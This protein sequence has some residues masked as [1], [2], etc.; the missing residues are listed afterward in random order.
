MILSLT[1]RRHCIA[2]YS[3]CRRSEGKAT[4][5]NCVAWRKSSRG[6][7]G[8]AERRFVRRAD[9]ARHRSVPDFLFNFSTQ[10]LLVVTDELDS[11]IAGDERLLDV[12]VHCC[13]YVAG[14][15]FANTWSPGLAASYMISLRPHH[16]SWICALLLHRSITFKCTT[17]RYAN[18]QLTLGI[19]FHNLNEC[20]TDASGAEMP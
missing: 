7:K 9:L 11:W 6:L 17:S 13:S 16:F 12:L 2:I 10:D 20:L 14:V 8:H 5:S 4:Q 18:D 15:C 19:I 1:P 3:C